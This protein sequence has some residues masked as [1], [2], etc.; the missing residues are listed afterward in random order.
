MEPRRE[1]F[2]KKPL[3]KSEKISIGLAVIH[4]II[5]ILQLLKS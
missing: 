3:S 5:G 2:K 1:K 4:I